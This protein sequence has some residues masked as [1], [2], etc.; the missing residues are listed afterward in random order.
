[1]LL[2]LLQLKW[3]CKKLTF[4]TFFWTF[5][6]VIFILLNLNFSHVMYTHIFVVFIKSHL[7]LVSYVS[8]WFLVV[9]NYMC[10]FFPSI[11]KFGG[12]YTFFFLNYYCAYLSWLCPSTISKY[13]I[14]FSMAFCCKKIRYSFD[15]T[16]WGYE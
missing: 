16:T 9:S 12:N 13:S 1:M 2:Q 15:V 10:T 5:F 3:I 7:G 6:K 11:V 8:M 14:H 4:L